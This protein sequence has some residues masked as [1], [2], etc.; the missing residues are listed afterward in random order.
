MVGTINLLANYDPIGGGVNPDPVSGV[1][2]V[3]ALPIQTPVSP[4]GKNMVTANTLTATITIVDPVTDKVVRM[5]PC[6]PGCHGVQYGAKDGGGYYAYVSSKFSNSLIVVDPDPNS[7]GNPTDAAIVGRILLTSTAGTA[8][9]DTVTG[10][11]GMGG[12]GLLTIPVVYNG[13]VQNLFDSWKN[14]LMPA[15]RNPIQ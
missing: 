5:L 2:F 9:D 8:S 14:Q 13:W 15:Q 12:Q 3:G 7:D 10:N 11:R 6:D 1:T 4:N